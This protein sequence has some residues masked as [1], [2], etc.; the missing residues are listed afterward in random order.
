MTGRTA[1]GSQGQ[2][3][4]IGKKVVSEDSAVSQLK[5]ALQAMHMN[6][7]VSSVVIKF[8]DRKD[9]PTISIDGI[10]YEERGRGQI[11]SISVSRVIKYQ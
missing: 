3:H 11:E 4:Q 6:Q 9:E 2:N 1:G 8:I 10:L 5:K 7:R